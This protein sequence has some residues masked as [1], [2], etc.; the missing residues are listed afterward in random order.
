M[1]AGLKDKL[2][3]IDKLNPYIDY[4]FVDFGCADGALINVLSQIKNFRNSVYIGYDISEEMIN[5]AKSK[6]D[7]ENRRV[8]FTTDWNVVQRIIIKNYSRCVLILSSVIHEV[9]SYAKSKDDIESF[10]NK[11]LNSQFD[12][13]VIR[14][15]IP[16]SDIDRRTAE[17]NYNYVMEHSDIRKV[18][19]F[20]NIWGSLTNNRNL[21][22][23][24]LKYRWTVNW[25]RE[26]RE[27]YFPIYLNELL[28]IFEKYP[29][30]A[31]NLDHLERFRVPFL[32]EYFQRT[33]GIV[34]NDYTHC[35]LMFSR[36]L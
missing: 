10:W 19:D 33:F 3:F 35:K 28:S 23:F 4:V 7:W 2:W 20:Q 17:Y 15:M 14:D 36:H 30:D 21:I 31:Y 25:D 9:Y 5:L 12:H 6:F 16:T 11:V 22:H 1:A 34:L 27:N 26:V 18:N 29:T 13:I 24:L 8:T 32:D